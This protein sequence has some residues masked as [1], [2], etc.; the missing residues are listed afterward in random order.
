MEPRRFRGIP[1]GAVGR[2]SRVSCVNV[3]S[4]CWGGYVTS[5]CRATTIWTEIT[6]SDVRVRYYVDVCV[7][8]RRDITGC[9]QISLFCFHHKGQDILEI[10]EIVDLAFI[11]TKTHSCSNIFIVII[12][13]IG[14]M[15]ILH[16]YIP[17]RMF[18]LCPWY[19]G[20]SEHV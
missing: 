11:F 18:L 17:F 7:S 10:C 5:V 13:C 4:V 6:P 1:L 9:Q 2:S 12:D 15:D 14:V 16:V 19:S 8:C 3:R 20:W